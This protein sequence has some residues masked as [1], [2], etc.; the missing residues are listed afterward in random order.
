VVYTSYP[1][2]QLFSHRR[3]P[4]AFQMVGEPLDPVF[5]EPEVGGDLV[6]HLDQ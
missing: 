4:E 1:L 2:G 6:R 3:R 5:M